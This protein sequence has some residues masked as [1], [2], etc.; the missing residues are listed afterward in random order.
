M[1]TIVY[2]IAAAATVIKKAIFTSKESIKANIISIATPVKK[3][4]VIIISAPPKLDIIVS[5][6]RS[7][8]LY[9]FFSDS[10]Y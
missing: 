8:N 5:I 4:M 3:H 6:S 9:A 1:A 10:T 2:P 7:L